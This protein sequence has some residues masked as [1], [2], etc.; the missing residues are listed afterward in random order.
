[1]HVNAADALAEDAVEM[2]VLPFAVKYNFVEWM[3]RTWVSKLVYPDVVI[4]LFFPHLQAQ[5]V[6]LCWFWC[7]KRRFRDPLSSESFFLSGLLFL[8]D[9]SKFLK[10]N[11]LELKLTRRKRA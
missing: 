5:S 1:M 7:V 9:A 4:I 11:N 10:L 3:T 2:A 8:P 6:F